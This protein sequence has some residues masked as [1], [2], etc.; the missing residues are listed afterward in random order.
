VSHGT[1]FS[2]TKKIGDDI[3]LQL[4]E[5]KCKKYKCERCGYIWIPRVELPSYCPSCGT[6]FR[7]SDN[8]HGFFVSNEYGEFDDSIC[9]SRNSDINDVDVNGVEHIK[10]DLI[11]YK[12][13][14]LE[15]VIHKSD[16]INFLKSSLI[17]YNFDTMFKTFRNIINLHELIKCELYNLGWN[18]GFIPM[19]EFSSRFK[20]FDVVWTKDSTVIAVFEINSITSIDGVKTSL[21]ILGNPQF[22]N[23][24]IDRNLNIDIHTGII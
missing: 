3:V 21:N 2:Q 19:V 9:I 11:G 6:E 1:I 14:G 4:E 12:N 13:S 17:K 8:N 18:M 16:I 7:S 20:I 15:I 23:V 22:F 10:S 5:A 24:I